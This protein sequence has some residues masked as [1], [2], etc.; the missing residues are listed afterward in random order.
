ML[1]EQVKR[2]PGKFLWT[3]LDLLKWFGI[4]VAIGLILGVLF[5]MA[6]VKTTSLNT[7]ESVHKRTKQG[8]GKIKTSSMNKSEKRSHKRYRG[9]G[10]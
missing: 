2:L 5:Q 1:S 8:T 3:T 10:R 9:Q 7:H 4:G 6:K